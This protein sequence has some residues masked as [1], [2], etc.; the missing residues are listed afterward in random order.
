M[1]GCEYVRNIMVISVHALPNTNK[2][3]PEQFYA[4]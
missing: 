2:A 1:C 4:F 3:V